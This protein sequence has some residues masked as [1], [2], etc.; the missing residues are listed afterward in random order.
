M[1]FG[2]LLLSVAAAGGALYAAAPAGALSCGGGFPWWSGGGLAGETEGDDGG[3]DWTVS[4]PVEPVPVDA[5]LWQ[6]VSCHYELLPCSYVSEAHTVEVDRE[7]ASDCTRKGHGLLVELV[8]REPLLAGHTYANTC[9]WG[10]PT[11]TTREGPAAPPEPVR[12]EAI[13]LDRGSDGPCSSGDRLD[14]VLADIDAAYLREGGRIELQYPEGHVLPVTPM[15][16]GFADGF[17]A[18]DGPVILRPVAVDGT[19]G[20]AVPIVDIRYNQAVLLLC[21][22]GEPR[23]WQALWM[24][25]PVLWL[26]AAAR[27]RRSR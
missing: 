19:R 15:T 8:P 20:E 14:L 24:L 25:G 12:V 7:P 5:R 27:R 17:P 6:F 4:D 9:A 13:G 21:A 16:L 2:L 18:T 3:D 11:F 26:F 22:V 1:R 10:E 23:P